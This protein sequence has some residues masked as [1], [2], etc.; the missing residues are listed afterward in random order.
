MK[1]MAQSISAGRGNDLALAAL[2]AA[3]DAGDYELLR[4]AEPRFDVDALVAALDRVRR[5]F[6][7]RSRNSD[8]TYRGICLQTGSDTDDPLYGLLNLRLASAVLATEPTVIAGEFAA[9]FAALSPHAVLDRGRLLELHPGHVMRFH[10]DGPGSRRLHIPLTTAPLCLLEFEDGGAYHLPA[11][12]SCY[13]ANT[14]R[15]H[16]V[17]NRSEVPRVHLVF[18]ARSLAA[19]RDQRPTPKLRARIT[20]QPARPDLDELRQC[21]GALDWQQV[22]HR[23]AKAGRIRA[24]DSEA[25][26]DGAALTLVTEFDTLEGLGE[27]LREG[28]LERL[29]SRLAER[30]YRLETEIS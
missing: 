3:L 30:G 11:D 1:A 2:G 21:L 12:G 17:T 25:S 10:S 24:R 15:A 7:L 9:V 5:R 20:R 16:R 13:L 19:A 4:L 27:F 6:A 14:E 8:P 18:Q 26:A 29:R 23:F 28:A 22:N